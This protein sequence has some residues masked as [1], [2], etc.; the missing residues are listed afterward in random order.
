VP[1]DPF[2]AS[3]RRLDGYYWNQ[4]RREPGAD[5]RDWT[6]G[7]NDESGDH[8]LVQDRVSPGCV[9]YEMNGVNHQIRAVE[10]DVMSGS[11]GDHVATSR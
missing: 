11:F 3:F 7:E 10:L 1:N 4:N 6:G 8:Y 5:K 9:Y 2:N